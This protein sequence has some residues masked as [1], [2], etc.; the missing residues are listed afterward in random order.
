MVDGNKVIPAQSIYDARENVA[1]RGM[2]GQFAYSPAVQPQ[3]DAS[4]G[5]CGD[6]VYVCVE[7]GAG[8]SVEALR[9]VLARLRYCVGEVWVACGEAAR[10]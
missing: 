3:Y 4:G 10:G 6:H 2:Q 1:N 9:W 5:E 7:C 8:G